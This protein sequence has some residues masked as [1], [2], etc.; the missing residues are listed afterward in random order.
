MSEID[1]AQ[2]GREWAFVRHG[3]TDWNLN[4]F[5]Q[6]R[7][8]IPLNETGRKQARQ[9]GRELKKAHTWSAVWSSPLSRTLETAE[10]IAEELGLAA[11]ATHPGIIERFY[12]DAEGAD[13]RSLTRQ[14]RERLLSLGEDRTAVQDRGIAALREI[15]RSAPRSSLL[16]V[17][18][19][20]FIRLML[21]RLTG[22][23]NA[24]VENGELR[25]FS[26]DLLA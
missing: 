4:G 25:S 18:H 22:K 10:I 2:S 11:P 12:G 20:S 7:T 21:D 26:L 14:E 15:Q 13:L 16:L 19:G 24:H 6:G 1:Y 9:L 3:Q 5:L 23:K 8:D 17:S